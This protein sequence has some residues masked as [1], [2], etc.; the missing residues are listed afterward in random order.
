[1]D[2]LNSIVYHFQPQFILFLRVDFV[3]RKTFILKFRGSSL[4]MQHY[5]PSW[6]LWLDNLYIFLKEM[7]FHYL[8]YDR[9]NSWSYNLSRVWS[10]TCLNF[11]NQTLPCFNGVT[12]QLK[13]RKPVLICQM[14]QILS[15]LTWVNQFK[16]F[17]SLLINS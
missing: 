7:T 9:P 2:Y 14:H 10:P 8:R 13:T 4:T 5:S 12:F 1:M 3:I 15:C 6:V 11:Q 17:Y 16:C